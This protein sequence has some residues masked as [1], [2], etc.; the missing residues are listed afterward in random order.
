MLGGGRSFAMITTATRLVAMTSRWWGLHRDVYR[1]GE[2]HSI[3]QVTGPIPANEG[4]TAA[5][6]DLH[7][8]AERYIKR[9]ESWH[10]INNG[11]NL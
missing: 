2:K 8:N 10:G 6:A 11:A 3:E 7:E 4:F 5:E 1:D 9:F